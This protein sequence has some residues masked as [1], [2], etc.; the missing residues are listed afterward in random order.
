MAKIATRKTQRNRIGGKKKY[1]IPLL[2]VLLGIFFLIVFLSPKK[3]LPELKTDQSVGS[4][5]IS[6]LV[7]GDSGTGSREQ[8][9]LAQIML[10]YQFDF[11]LHTGDVAYPYGSDEFYKW[12]FFDVY[13]EHL[14]RVTF[15]PSPGNHDYQN[16]N[17]TAYLDVFG[18][19][20]YYSFDQGN[21]HF[22]ALDTNA[23]LDLVSETETND[24][25]HWLGKDL[26]NANE[27]LWKI[28]FFHHPPY[29]SGSVHGGDMRVR[30][31]IVP[32]LE[33]YNVD[34]V[35]SGHEHHYERTCPILADTCVETGVVY[36]VTGGGGARLYDF[37][38]NSSVTRIAKKAHHFL[39]V[40]VAS[41]VLKARAIGLDLSSIDE[42]T[43]DKC[44]R[45]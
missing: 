32:I 29:S 13:S 1:V 7:F 44:D 41:C 19:E 14:K 8:K 37:G 35:F 12:N 30:E 20:R 23:P 38:N 16:D 39:Q 6:F 25:A 11:I 43:V 40:E 36:I 17:L 34:I 26:E 22:V 5:E 45:N 24:M 31:K 15:F 33:K 10:Q 9:E 18:R 21:V 42:F 27:S 3:K 2:F 28:V 4:N